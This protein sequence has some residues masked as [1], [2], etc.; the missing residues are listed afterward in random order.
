MT[1][2]GSYEL[3]NTMGS[4]NEA[5]SS[6]IVPLDKKCIRKLVFY[7]RLSSLCLGASQNK[8]LGDSK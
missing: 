3:E 6:Q 2:P 4:Q 1:I 7:T 8:T 5:L